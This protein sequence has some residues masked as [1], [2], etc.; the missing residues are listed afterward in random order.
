VLSARTL[1]R[2]DACASFGV[3]NVFAGTAPS[4][5]LIWKMLP[6][7]GMSTNDKS[8]DAS[9]TGEKADIA[10]AD[11]E[12]AAP[13]PPAPAVPRNGA[14]ERNTA[15][16]R[17]GGESSFKDALH[18]AKDILIA[19]VFALV[20][21]VAAVIFPEWTAPWWLFAGIAIFAWP[22]STFARAKY[23]RVKR[24]WWFIPLVCIVWFAITYAAERYFWPSVKIE[25]IDPKTAFPNTDVVLKGSGFTERPSLMRVW[26][27]AQDGK[28]GDVK[29]SV[30]DV[31]EGS[32]QIRVPRD[33]PPGDYTVEITGPLSLPVILRNAASTT[34][35]VMGAPEVHSVEPKSGIRPYGG[36]VTRVTVRGKYFDPAHNLVLFGETPAFA[37]NCDNGD[38]NCLV[39]SVPTD[40]PE[41]KSVEISVE[42]GAQR[43]TAGPEKFRVLGRS[44]IS[45]L[46][47]SPWFGLLF[48]VDCAV[49]AHSLVRLV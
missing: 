43:G 38:S 32:V 46:L 22:I 48:F 39:A 41:G 36:Q 45:S 20:F 40:A 28:S 6:E 24:W 19:A 49:S 7:A 21:A 37:H 17:E 16:D 2:V 10:A 30:R 33:L 25:S 13:A 5:S 15:P 31:E 9:P 27:S 47:T 35:T 34:L 8:P 23:P 14:A 18:Q 44:T 12:R 4:D 11:T 26:F 29:T 1:L 42:A 3:K